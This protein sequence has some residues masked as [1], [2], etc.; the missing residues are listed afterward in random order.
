MDGELR[1]RFPD[2]PSPAAVGELV[3]RF[4][5]CCSDYPP[6]RLILGPGEGYRL[7][8]G[9]LILDGYREGK[10]E[11]DVLLLISHEGP[12]SSGV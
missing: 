2:Q 10:Q 8:Q 1:R 12:P 3:G 5:R 9:G 6:V 11:P 7:P 4:L